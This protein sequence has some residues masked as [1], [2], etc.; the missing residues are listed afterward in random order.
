MVFSSHRMKYF[1]NTTP[2]LSSVSAHKTFL[3]GGHFRVRHSKPEVIHRK[4][5]PVT[6]FVLFLK[7]GIL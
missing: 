2:Q 3:E 1:S 7:I 4:Y 5:R 6:W